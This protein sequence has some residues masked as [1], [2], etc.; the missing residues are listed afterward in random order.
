MNVLVD[1]LTLI[2]RRFRTRIFVTVLFLTG[3]GM[4]IHADWRIA[5]AVLL[6]NTAGDIII[7]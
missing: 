1:A 3:Y 6:I 5:I 4:L 7:S 2:K